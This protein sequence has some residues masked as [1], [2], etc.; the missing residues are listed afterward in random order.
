MRHKKSTIKVSGQEKAL[1]VV[2]FV[3]MVLAV[4]LC[5]YPF[6][7]LIIYSLSDPAQASRGVWLLPKD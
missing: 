7:Y 1:R 3:C 5:M 6:W 2:N 4:F